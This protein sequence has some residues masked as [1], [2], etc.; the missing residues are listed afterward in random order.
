[1]REE[2]SEGM[3]EEGLELRRS[4]VAGSEVRRMNQIFAEDFLVT[5][6]TGFR[7]DVTERTDG[8]PPGAR[9]VALSSR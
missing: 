8:L 6:D 9:V 3:R 4:A 2:R 5:E 1:M 7:T